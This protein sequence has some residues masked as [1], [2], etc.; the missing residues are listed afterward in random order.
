MKLPVVFDIDGTICWDGRAIPQDIL[1]ELRLLRKI[2]QI[3]F[4]SARPIRDL[5]PVLPRHFW[6]CSLVGGNGAWVQVGSERHCQAFEESQRAI[7]DDWIVQRGLDYLVDG[8]WNYDYVGDPC[9]R[10]H[11]QIDA[12]HLAAQV[13]R[14]TLE[15]Y[16]K[17]VLFTTDQKVCESLRGAGLM[18]KRHEG[19]GLID[20]APAGISKY[21]TLHGFVVREGGYVAFGNDVNDEDL[22][23]HAVESFGVGDHPAVASADHV[24]SPD[25]V[26]GAIKRLA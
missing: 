26:A 22:L 21:S 19:E 5:L 17:A 10:I 18:V 2:R 1:E 4:A 3:I 23:A 15:F 11:R 20:I 8:A 25:E 7:V 16:A 24:L 6:D 9:H 12:G 14:E 13:P